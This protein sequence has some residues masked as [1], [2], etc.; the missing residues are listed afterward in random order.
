MDVA[1]KATYNDGGNGG[2]I[3][4]KGVCSRDVI[5]NNMNKV[6]CSMKDNS[7]KIFFDLG[8]KGR[9]PQKNDHCYESKLFIDWKFGAGIY[10]SGAKN[11]QPIPIAKVNP[12]DLAVV[13]T[14]FPGQKEQDRI[15]V[16][17][18]KIAKVD[19]S[20]QSTMGTMLVADKHARLE[21]N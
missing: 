13:T 9:K 8:L 5:V 2:F 16:G 3:G 15:I 17:I 19:N 14:R 18:Y 10:H 12:G 21:L 4:F 20:A 6:N 7:C 1:L 11:G